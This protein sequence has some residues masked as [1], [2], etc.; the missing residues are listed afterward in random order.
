[1]ETYYRIIMKSLSVILVILSFISNAC[2]SQPNTDCMDATI[3]VLLS[4]LGQGLWTN[5]YVNN[6]VHHPVGEKNSI[7]FIPEKNFSTDSLGKLLIHIELVRW[8]NQKDTMNIY[9][10][11]P[12]WSCF[13]DYEFLLK[14]YA[15]GHYIIEIRPDKSPSEIYFTAIDPAQMIKTA[16]IALTRKERLKESELV[17][18]ENW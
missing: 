6:V 9:I 18:Y 10:K 16:P 17:E 4:N 5:L 14:E 11:N 2:F 15:C 1:M 3:R 12:C 13:T 8:E 7:C